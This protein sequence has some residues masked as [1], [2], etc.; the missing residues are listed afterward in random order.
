MT[1][2]HT[3]S[4]SFQESS[5]KQNKL[6][7]EI[8]KILPLE[9]WLNRENLGAFGSTKS[10]GDDTSKTVSKS[11]HGKST[12]KPKLLQEVKTGHPTFLVNKLPFTVDK[13]GR[14]Y[15]I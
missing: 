12:S 9:R 2:F 3:L 4:F 10:H 15:L 13:P 14:N 5:H 7:G 6:K 1:D 8:K 11:N